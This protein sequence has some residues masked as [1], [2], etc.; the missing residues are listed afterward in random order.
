[1]FTRGIESFSNS[2]SIQKNICSLLF[3]HV[4]VIYG[5]QRDFLMS[6]E[7]CKDNWNF[8]VFTVGLVNFLLGFLTF[9]MPRIAKISRET[10]LSEW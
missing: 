10:R 5:T 1:M 3:P 2:D 9:N 4:S 7:V 8:L 6:V